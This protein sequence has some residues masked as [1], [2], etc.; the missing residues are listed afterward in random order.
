MTFDDALAEVAGR[1]LLERDRLAVLWDLAR[2]ANG[3]AGAFAEVGVSCGGASKLLSL[4]TEKTVYAFDTFEGLPAT[5]REGE[6]TLALMPGRFAADAKTLDWLGE[7]PNIV[8]RRGYFPETARGLEEERFSL[9][10]LDGDLYETTRAGIGFFWPRL[11]G[12]LVLDD[13][14]RADTPGVLRAVW[15][16]GIGG[17]LWSDARWLNQLVLYK[18]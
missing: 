5:G 14:G 17:H 2:R 6:R 7:S 18:G 15:E 1:T 9:V 8:T 13:Y 11:H 10:H 4:A 12:W 16:S 3:L